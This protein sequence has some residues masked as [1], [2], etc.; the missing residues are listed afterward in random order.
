MVLHLIGGA[1]IIALVLKWLSWRK[2]EYLHYN[3]LTS[4][5]KCIV[6]LLITIE[7]I[8]RLWYRKVYQVV[9]RYILHKKIYLHN[10][11]LT[12]YFE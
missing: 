5:V 10:N 6:C 3:L 7:R 8:V 4:Y 2:S 1:L 11:L 9:I 12:S